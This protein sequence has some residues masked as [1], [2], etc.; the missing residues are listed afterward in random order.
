M[1]IAQ[2]DSAHDETTGD[3]YY[4]TFAPG[5][6]M[7]H[8]DSVYVVNFASLHRLAHE[9]MLRSDVLVLNQV[10]Y[11]D[12]LPVIRDRKQLKK[13]TVYEISDEIEDV[14]P[15]SPAKG[16]YQQPNNLLLMKRLA[17]YCD[18]LQF[19]SPELRRKYGY[20]NSNCCVFPNQIL[21]AP[22]ER[23]KKVEET[24]IVGWAVPS[25]TCMTSQRS[26]IASS[27]G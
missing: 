20:L 16:F 13:L 24:V 1:L 6:A 21:A 26:Q 22:R 17:H 9:V 19:Q 15:P 11:P 23:Q 10:C 2:V 18:A 5:A 8:C 3:F 12:L 4:R 25:V 7:A 14:P 27:I